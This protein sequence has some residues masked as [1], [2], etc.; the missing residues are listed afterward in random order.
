[1]TG[2]N[3]AAEQ[4]VRLSLEGVEVLAKITGAGAKNIAAALYII[5]KEEN[6]NSKGKTS[7][8]K[9]LKTGKPVEIFALKTEDLK[10]F[11]SEAKRYGVLYCT[12]ANDKSKTVDGMV[13]IM[14]KADDA[15]IV[16]RIVERFNLATVDS[17]KMET[18]LSDIE[19]SKDGDIPK[20]TQVV[21]QNEEE[22]FAELMSASKEEG[23]LGIENP[24]VAMTD[25]NP[26]LEQ[27]SE[28]YK[29]QNEG[30]TEPG[31]KPS[32]RAKLQQLK[33]G[34]KLE[35]EGRQTR[36]KDISL[37]NPK[38]ENVKKKMFKERANR[39]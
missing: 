10:K 8:T 2:S 11:K 33:A 16:N 21:E 1:M 25:K 29:N 23:E 31:E 26:P 6:K 37:P 4:V 19:Q 20:E 32:V 14:V 18:T 9:I 24:E 36:N 3:D 22:I 30:V 13:D 5:M 27:S 17:A 34:Q 35:S 12:L 39:L 15:G 28:S 38:M 7:L